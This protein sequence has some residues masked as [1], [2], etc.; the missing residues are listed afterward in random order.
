MHMENAFRW[1]CQR[2]DLHRQG[3]IVTR[4]KM[5]T[6][7]IIAKTTYLNFCR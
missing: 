5:S 2:P 4:A 1:F 7:T 3:Y 6:R